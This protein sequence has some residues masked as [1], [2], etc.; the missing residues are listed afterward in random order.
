MLTSGMKK[1]LIIYIA[2]MCALIFFSKT[3]Y[4]YSLPKVA[5]SE[6]KSGA[7]TKNFEN[8]GQ[9]NFIKTYDIFTDISGKVIS[10]YAEEGAAVA[11]FSDIALIEYRAEEADIQ[12]AQAAV[13]KLKLALAQAE[14]EKAEIEKSIEDIKN[15]PD[16]DL[17]VTDLEIAALETEVSNKKA[18]EEKQLLLYDEGIIAQGEYIS[19]VN[20]VTEAENRLLIRYAQREEAIK[21]HISGIES[22]IAA[23]ESALADAASSIN[24]MA[25]EIN[26]ANAE[27][28]NMREVKSQTV[29]TKDSDGILIETFIQEGE[30]TSRGSKAA[31][32]GLVGD[33]FIVEITESKESAGFINIKDIAS[34]N[35]NGVSVDAAVFKI[36][37]DGENL[38]LSFKINPENFRGFEYGAVT[39]TKTTPEYEML[40]PNEAVLR[41]AFGSNVWVLKQRRG[42]LG[43]EYYAEKVKVFTA[44]FDESFTAVERGLSAWDIVIL[45]PGAE[46]ENKSRVLPE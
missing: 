12:R 27:L 8:F 46:L 10:V 16:I 35:V 26:A 28:G 44:D 23:K 1:Q 36:E 29:K 25:F 24:Q 19:A 45:N 32:I 9:L 30:L 37:P 6:V 15:T 2:V 39:L 31:Q 33:G 3:I 34:F 43:T 42:L 5:V 38:K 22:Q 40:V 41:D 13:E 20:A 18:E 17:T 14:E 11:P 4:N 21:N 7:L